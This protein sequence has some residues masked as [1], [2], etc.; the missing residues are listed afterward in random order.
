V[1]APGS[2][3]FLIKLVV[4]TFL[5][6]IN[7]IWDIGRGGICDE[8]RDDLARDISFHLGFA[9]DVIFADSENAYARTAMDSDPGTNGRPKISEKK[10]SGLQCVFLFA[11][12]LYPTAQA[13]PKREWAPNANRGPDIRLSFWNRADWRTPSLSPVL[14][15]CRGLVLTSL[16]VGAVTGLVKT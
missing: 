11:G 8:R 2:R 15:H 7:W 6:E 3:I 1:S 16:W 12:V 14:S 10:I 5:W 13:R 9:H 4:V